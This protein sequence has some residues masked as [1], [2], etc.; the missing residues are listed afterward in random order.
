MS[1]PGARALTN[2]QTSKSLA[3]FVPRPVFPHLDSI[4]RSY[5]LG[6]HRA[7]LEK[8]KSMISQIDLII[9]CRDYRTPLVSRNPMFEETLGEKPRLIVH[10][11][12]DLGDSGHRATQMRVR[13]T[14]FL[15]E[16]QSQT[17]WVITERGNYKA[18]E[19]S[20]EGRLLRRQ[21]KRYYR[22]STQ[23]HKRACQR[24]G[25][26]YWLPFDGRRHA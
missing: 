17:D 11:K 23:T 15:Y 20:L 10:T 3:G 24:D 4:P 19:Q 26:S 25:Q 22:N 18:M 1:S 6:H 14:L 16:V 5:F 21:A 13:H 9:E 12:R 2:Q 8:M 7:G